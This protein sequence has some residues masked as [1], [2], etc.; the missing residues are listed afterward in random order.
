MSEFVNNFGI[1]WKLLVAQAINFFVLLIILKKFAYK[2]ILEMLRKRK[3]EIEAGIRMKN[4]AEK[5]LGMA[6]EL[7]ERA[8]EKARAEALEIVSRAEETAKLHKEEILK[9][10]SKKAESAISDARK[11]IDE[12]KAKMSEELRQSAGALVRL[13]IEKTLQK[14][15]ASE[16]DAKLIKEAL[17]EITSNA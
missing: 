17:S 2:P 1:D 9:T 6:E 15:P 3:S 10:A 4:E 14:M 12:E 11:L 8:L 7:K 13:G 5:Q 16:R